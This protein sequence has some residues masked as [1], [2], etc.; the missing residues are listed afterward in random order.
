VKRLAWP[1]GLLVV[2]I[3]VIRTLPALTRPAAAPDDCERVPRT[4]AAAMERCLTLRP[5]DVELMVDLADGYRRAGDRERATALYRRA[6][7][8][9]PDD[10]DVRRRLGAP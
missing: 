3:V 5:D 6:L 1:Y 4:D 9:D 8:V 7:A 2:F 10:G